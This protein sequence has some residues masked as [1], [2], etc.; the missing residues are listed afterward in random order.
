MPRIKCAIIYWLKKTRKSINKLI[1]RLDKVLSRKS[2]K[3][4]VLSFEKKIFR[5]AIRN[6]VKKLF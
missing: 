3:N 5:I 2:L 1:L 4:K 6:K